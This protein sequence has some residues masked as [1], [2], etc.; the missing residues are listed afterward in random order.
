MNELANVKY[1]AHDRAIA[2]SEQVM[3]EYGPV[4]QRLAREGTDFLQHSI[5][6]KTMIVEYPTPIPMELWEF[7]E[8]FVQIIKPHHQ[9]PDY[10]I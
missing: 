7:L 5:N 8:K 3:A 4:F 1:A 2:V 9:E 6:G 10:S